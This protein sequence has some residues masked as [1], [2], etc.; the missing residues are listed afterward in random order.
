MAMINGSSALCRHQKVNMQLS[1]NTYPVTHLCKGQ[2]H[3]ASFV[4]GVTR[5]DAIGIVAMRSRP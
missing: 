3:C 4:K 5:H 1:A 2:W